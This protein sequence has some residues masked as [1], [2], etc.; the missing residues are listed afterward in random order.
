MQYRLIPKLAFRRKLFLRSAIYFI[1][2]A[3]TLFEPMPDDMGL[4]PLPEPPPPADSDSMPIL[5]V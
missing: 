5:T 4:P 3:P 1:T 2:T